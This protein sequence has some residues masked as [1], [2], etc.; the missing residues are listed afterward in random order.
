MMM[1]MIMMMMMMMMIVILI[2]TIISI[3]IINSI[4]NS[5]NNITSI[6]INRRRSRIN[7]NKIVTIRIIN[8]IGNVTSNNIDILI[9]ISIIIISNIIGNICLTSEVVKV[10]AASEATTTAGFET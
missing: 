1:M 2:I 10:A 6:G 4:S 5:S 9:K 8:I 3:I 7:K